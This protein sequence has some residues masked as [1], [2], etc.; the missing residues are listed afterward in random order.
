LL[1]LS[2]EDLRAAPLSL[3][4]TR[5]E[6]GLEDEFE[7]FMQFWGTDGNWL[8]CLCRHWVP[9]TGEI[10]DISCDACTSSVAWKQDNCSKDRRKFT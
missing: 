6:V 9:L 7:L 4:V 10:L 5:G 1:L 3:S 8:G 2:S